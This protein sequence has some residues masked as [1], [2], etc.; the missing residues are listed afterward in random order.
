[1]YRKGILLL[2]AALVATLTAATVATGAPPEKRTLCTADGETIEIP[3][4]AKGPK[5]A[6]EGPCEETP[7]GPDPA[8]VQ[9]CTDMGGQMITDTRCAVTFDGQYLEINQYAWLV[10]DLTV[11]YEWYG[12]QFVGAPEYDFVTKGCV[13]QING[14]PVPLWDTT[15]YDPVHNPQT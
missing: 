6:T 13:S 2:V 3:N 11:Y 10:G 9:A 8:A 4:H 14:Y 5:G 1:M 15:C 7:T 12:T